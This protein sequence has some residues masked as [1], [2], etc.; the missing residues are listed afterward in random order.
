MR[1]YEIFTAF[2]HEFLSLS[3]FVCATVKHMKSEVNNLKWHKNIAFFHSP[4]VLPVCI[5]IKILCLTLK[6]TANRNKKT[7]LKKRKE[8]GNKMLSLLKWKS[9]C[10]TD[11]WDFGDCK[12]C[13]NNA[14]WMTQFISA[15]CF[16]HFFLV[17]VLL[18]FLSADTQVHVKKYEDFF[19]GR[20]FCCSWGLIVL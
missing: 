12:S 14:W 13:K 17:S 2:L 6:C 16:A 3:L 11:R 18:W 20:H 10:G 19:C 8:N 5:A 9:I 4:S 15:V 1:Y 7:S